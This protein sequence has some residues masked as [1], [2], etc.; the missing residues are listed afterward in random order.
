MISARVCDDTAGTFFVSERCNLVV[1]ATQ[2]ESAD[3]LQ[4]FRLEIKLAAVPLE[5]N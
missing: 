3:G 1:S 2:F 4:I 5:G